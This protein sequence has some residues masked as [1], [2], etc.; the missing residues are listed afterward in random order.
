MQVDA[1]LQK[2]FAG[3]SVPAYEVNEQT[4]D[5]LT[6]LK[7]ANERQDKYSQLMVNDMQVKADEYQVE[8]MIKRLLL[9]SSKPS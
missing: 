2:V 1:W 3:Q 5:L 6:E 7:Q 4:L 9:Y 8:G